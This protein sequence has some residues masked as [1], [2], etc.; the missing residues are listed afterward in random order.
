L[1]KVA[2]V[3][4]GLCVVVDN[5]PV[6]GGGDQRDPDAYEHWGETVIIAARLKGTSPANDIAIFGKHPAAREGSQRL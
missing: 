3:E 2:R 1:G 4:M 5:G 6:G